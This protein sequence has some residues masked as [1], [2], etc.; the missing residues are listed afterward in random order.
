MDTVIYVSIFYHDTYFGKE[1]ILMVNN[2]SVL[3]HGVVDDCPATLT[4][5]VYQPG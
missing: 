4:T 2:E 5:F 1:I 3:L